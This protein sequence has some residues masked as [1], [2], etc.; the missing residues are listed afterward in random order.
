LFFGCYD[1]LPIPH[2]FQELISLDLLTE[3]GNHTL[4]DNQVLAGVV[5]ILILQSALEL[6]YTLLKSLAHTI[7]GS[8]HFLYQLD[9][10]VQVLDSVDHALEFFLSEHHDSSVST[11]GNLFLRYSA[12]LDKGDGFDLGLHLV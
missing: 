12:S 11:N 9:L 3:N 4:A 7:S 8:S 5:A 10:L 6:V 1:F 2:F